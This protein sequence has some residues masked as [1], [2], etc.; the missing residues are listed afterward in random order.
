M[1]F[2]YGV[3]DAG[4]TRVIGGTG[5]NP[6]SGPGSLE[7]GY[8]IRVDEA[9][10]GFGTKVAAALTR[11]AF[12]VNLVQRVEIR[13]NPLNEPSAAIPRKLGFIYEGTLR[14]RIPAAD[15]SYED[16][17]VWT[18]LRSEYEGSPARAYNVAA[19]DAVGTQLL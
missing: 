12:E 1:T 2:R 13:C 3:F 9:Q 14:K 11:V 15:G 8:W 16:T 4:D 18:M 6:R 19:F 10:K 17:M 7:I 5:L